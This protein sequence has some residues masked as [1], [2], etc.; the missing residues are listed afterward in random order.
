MV[1]SRVF[2]PFRSLVS[3]SLL[4]SV[5]LSAGF[6]VEKDPV[7]APPRFSIEHM[8]TKADPRTD[9]A[10]YAGG[11]WRKLN[12]VPADK[13][14]WGSFWELGQANLRALHGLVEAAA[15]DPGEAGTARRLVADF[16]LS[17]MDTAAID[18]AG[19]EPIRADL[20]RIAE[21]R[22]PADLVGLVAALHEFNVFALFD[23]DVR[24][25][26]KDSGTNI[27]VLS[28]A[29]LSLP[30]KDQYFEESFARVRE[31]FVAHVARLFQLAGDDAAAAGAAA[32]VVFDVEK[33]LAEKSRSP[34]ELRDPVANY[35]K[36]TVAELGAKTPAFDFG[37]YF[38]R[39]GLPAE[40]NDLLVVGQPEF[41]E[42]LQEQ[43]ARR[44]VSDWKTYFRFRLLSTAGPFLGAAFEEETFRFYQTA[45]RGTPAMEPRWQ[46][47]VRVVDAQIGEA[48]GRMYVERYYPP[49]AAARM[50]EMIRNLLAALRDRLNAIDWMTPETRAEAL[51]KLDRVYAKIGHPV[52]WKDYASLKLTRDGYWANVRAARAFEVRREVARAGR[53]VDKT[54]WLMSPPTVNAFFR[55]ADNSINFPAGIL[56]PPFFDFTLDDAVN[57]GAIGVI[58]GHEITHGFDDKGRKFDAEGN[59]RDW[60]TEADA[61]EFEARASKL[62]DQYAGYEALPG[63]RVN[64]ALTLGEN[65]ADLG[66]VTLAYAALQKALAGKPRERIDGYTPEQR[67]FIAYAQVWKDNIREDALRQQIAADPHSPGRFRAIGPLVNFAPFYEAFG[68]QEGD[69]MWLPPEKRTRIW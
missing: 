69:P 60:W 37:R 35:H 63:L 27:G 31:Q 57:Y 20:E 25:D 14:R 34:A 45:L 59:L 22:S 32:R 62:R 5:L 51:R 12:P 61:T 23:W 24:P 55:A 33:S 48:L 9:F 47:V 49:E 6:C 11:T 21:I 53:P 56:Q 66:G 39:R 30:T 13:A 58:I 41:F 46:R 68:I 19:I 42:G 1:Y 10:A 43:M 64:G 17:G 18:A 16:Y 40:P 67:F 8:D 28:Q 65:I 52:R 2:P 36:M 3:A 26:A 50:D 29:G 7:A 4:G 44:P 54:E 15:A 38:A